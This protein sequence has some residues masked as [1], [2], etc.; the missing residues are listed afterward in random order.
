LLAGIALCVATGILIKHGKLRYAWV[1]AMPLAWLALVTTTA[2]WQKLVE[3]HGFLAAADQ[4]A[5]K[6][7]AGTLPPEQAAVAPQLIFNQRLDAVLAVLLTL[8]LWVVIVDTVR[9]SARVVRGLPVLP[10]S[11]AVVAEVRS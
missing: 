7:A 1:T 3:P 4:L 9:V 6:L 11:E 8:L 10:S 2:T 5:A